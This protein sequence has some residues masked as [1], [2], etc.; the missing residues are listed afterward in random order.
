MEQNKKSNR[1]FHYRTLNNLCTY[2]LFLFTF[3]IF[4]HNW[5]LTPSLSLIKYCMNNENYSPW[6]GKNYYFLWH[7]G[8]ILPTCDK[9]LKALTF[10]LPAD[11][12]AILAE[13]HCIMQQCQALSRN[14]FFFFP[15]CGLESG[16][17]F[18]FEITYYCSAHICL[19]VGMRRFWVSMVDSKM[20][21]EKDSFISRSHPF[22]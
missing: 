6:I 22:P 15:L 11:S 13:L 7:R 18:R 3:S 9:C 19:G 2:E 20:H 17:L 10:D 1:L 12:K 8:L 21:Q 14:L 16:I 5:C 4:T